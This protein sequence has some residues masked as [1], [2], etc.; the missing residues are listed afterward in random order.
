MKLLVTGGAGFIGSN[1]VRHVLSTHPEDQI[2]VLD[3]L[4]YAGRR[5]NLADLED[6]PRFSFHPRR[7]RRPR[8]RRRRDRGLRRDRQLR[9]RD[10]RRPLD[11]GSRRLHHDR[12]VRHPRAARGRAR[13]EDRPLPADLDRRGLRLD[14]RRLLHRDVADR[15]LLALLGQQG[16]RRH[17][18][19]GLLPHLRTSGADHPRLEQLR[20]V[21]LPREADPAVHPRTPSPATSCRSTAT[22]CRCATGSTSRITAA[23]ST[24]CCARAPRA[25]STTSAAPTSARTSRS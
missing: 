7:D 19:A 3:K 2:V 4:T 11:R 20:A 8:G 6:D 21:P 17:A 5:E 1:F 22:A 25:R 23:A 14:R 10:P 12:R 15:P 18:R 9:R 13:R 16:R 24:P